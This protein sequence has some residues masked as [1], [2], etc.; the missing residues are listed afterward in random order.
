MADLRWR[1]QDGGLPF[2]IF[3]F[4]ASYCFFSLYK[5]FLVTRSYVY[6]IK[7]MTL[8]ILLIFYV[9]KWKNNKKH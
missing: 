7:E 3:N 8:P 5:C 9:S 1:I 6:Y 4:I 2:Q